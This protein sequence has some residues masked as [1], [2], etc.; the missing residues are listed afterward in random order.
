MEA[1]LQRRF[2]FR[3]K[4]SGEGSWFVVCTPL[5]SKTANH[6]CFRQDRWPFR[7]TLGG[8]S[9]IPTPNTNAFRDSSYAYVVVS[10]SARTFAKM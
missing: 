6:L 4:P 5:S 2:G 3:V 8:Q 9:L 7:P 10:V 1:L